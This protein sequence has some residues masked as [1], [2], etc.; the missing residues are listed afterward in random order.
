[1]PAVTISR[2]QGFV[3]SRSTIDEASRQDISRW[4]NRIWAVIWPLTRCS[5]LRNL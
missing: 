2:R 4:A 3:R 1:M 5:A